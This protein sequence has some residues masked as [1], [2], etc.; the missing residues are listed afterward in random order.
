MQVSGTVR[1]FG[2]VCLELERWQLFG[3]GVIGQTYTVSDTQDGVWHPATEQPPCQN[4]PDQNFLI[5]P[6]FDAPNGAYRMCP[7]ADQQPCIEFSKIP[8]EDSPGP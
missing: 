1:R 6:P 5:R 7:L 8:F 4:L 2:G 3:W